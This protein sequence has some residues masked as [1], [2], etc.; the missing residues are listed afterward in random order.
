MKL[1]LFIIILFLSI[2]TSFAAEN[3]YGIVN[4]WFNGKNATVEGF[5]MKIGEPAEIKV[6]VISKIDGNVY[7]ELNEPGITKSYN[8][9]NGLSKFDESIDNL[10]IESGWSKT[11]T[12]IVA[13]NGAWKNG[14]AP[15]NIFVEFSKIKTDKKIQFTIANPYILDEQYSSSTPAQTTGAAQPSPTGT[16]SP[17][18]PFISALVALAV[19]LGVW[20]IKKKTNRR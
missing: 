5:S 2:Q 10:K 3:E 15:I 9:V 8:V 13:P 16:S 4:A 14:N 17:Q 20:T 6:E 18:A 11:F 19:I 1:V 7:I 12:W